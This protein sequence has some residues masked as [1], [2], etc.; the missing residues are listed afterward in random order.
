MIAHHQ[1]VL[2]AALLSLVGHRS[3]A[4]ARASQISHDPPWNSEHISRL[5]EEIRQGA[6]PAVWGLSACR[7]L[8]CDL[9]GQ[10][11]AGESAF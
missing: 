2:A 6:H 3:A 10:F 11:Q 5:P 8:L 4:V 9:F 7:A 1:I